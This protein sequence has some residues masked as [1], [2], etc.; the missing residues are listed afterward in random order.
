MLT[1]EYFS[2][3]GFGSRFWLST[4]DHLPD[5]SPHK[6]A[7]LNYVD[8]LPRRLE[9]GMGL[10]LTGLTGGGKTMAAALLTKEIVKH[11]GYV[12]YIQEHEIPRIYMQR[13]DERRGR[14]IRRC[15]SESDRNLSVKDLQEVQWLVIDDLGASSGKETARCFTEYVI[16][17]RYD[18]MMPLIVTTNLTLA[19][20][21]DA[22]GEPCAR[23]LKDICKNIVIPVGQEQPALGVDAD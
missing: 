4:W 22:Y 9:D 7:L 16:R 8:G 20:I 15:S 14:G 1:E 12:L 13:D 6:M 11:S 2:C 3:T 5:G 19:Q 18:H 10:R 17:I 21:R 23:V